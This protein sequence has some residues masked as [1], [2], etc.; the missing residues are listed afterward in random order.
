ML[1][2]KCSCNAVTY[3]LSSRPMFVHCCHC[4][5]C[6]RLSGAAYLLNALIETDRV[7][8]RGDLTAIQLATPSGSGKI[9][10]RCAACGDAVYSHYLIRGNR[11]AFVRVGTLDHPDSCPPDVQIFT[12][13]KQ[14]WVPLS[15]DIP[16]FEAF[17][18]VDEHWPDSSLVR[19][20][21]V[22]E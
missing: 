4:H 17:Y 19:R 21:A 3:S 18:D 7:L 15:S 11:I 20:E 16:A 5:D 6:Q 12:G 1:S 8:V 14:A 2:G 22:T 9:V 10:M 13:S